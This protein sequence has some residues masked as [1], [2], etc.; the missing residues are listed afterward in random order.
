MTED[1]MWLQGLPSTIAVIE[2]YI[3]RSTTDV[4][5]IEYR[6]YITTETW[7]KTHELQGASYQQISFMVH[8]L[9][10]KDDISTLTDITP[11]VFL[12]VYLLKYHHFKSVCLSSRLSVDMTHLE[13][14]VPAVM[15][16]RVDI[17]SFDVNVC[18]M[19]LICWYDAPWS[20]CVFLHVAVVM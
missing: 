19:K 1:S 10:S 17:S 13:I 2:Y 18:T 14:H 16:V 4:D 9:T 8:T 3:Y 15:S 7:R 5:F 12:H 6:Y 20:S 11:C